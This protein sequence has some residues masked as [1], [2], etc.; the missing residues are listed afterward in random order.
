MCYSAKAV[1]NALIEVAREE[2]RPITNLVLQKMVFLAHGWYLGLTKNPLTC[3]IIEAWQYGPVFPSL[4]KA[5]VKYGAGEVTEFIPS[6]DRILE[7]S[8]TFRFIKIIFDKYG[9]Y[10]S[11]QLITLTHEKDSPWNKTWQDGRGRNLQIDNY[12]ILQYY[13]KKIENAGT[14]D[15]K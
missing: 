15:A 10:T 14:G 2:N 7:N 6:K 1:A 4:Y 3:D 12:S 8:E 13:S 5:L 11:G 9:Q